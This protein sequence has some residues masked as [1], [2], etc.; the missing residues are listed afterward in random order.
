MF[1]FLSMLLVLG[2][3]AKVV[4]TMNKDDIKTATDDIEI[5]AH[6]E[7]FQEKLPKTLENGTRIDKLEYVD[8]VVRMYVTE[9]FKSEATDSQ[10][11]KYKKDMTAAY[12]KGDMR[13][14]YKAKA[15]M[16]FNFKTQPHSLNDL[17]SQTW[18]VTMEPADCR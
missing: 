11:E 15:R 8:R 1:R 7:K 17:S 9:A 12:C 16:E 3:V 2:V 6:I 14:F 13:S 10:K 5:Q 18:K 4:Y